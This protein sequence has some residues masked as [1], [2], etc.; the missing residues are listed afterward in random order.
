[1]PQP[2]RITSNNANVGEENTTEAQSATG[3][4]VKLAKITLLKAE[5]AVSLLTQEAAKRWHKKPMQPLILLCRRQKSLQ[6]K[7]RL[8]VG[9]SP[10]RLQNRQG[11]LMKQLKWLLI[12][13]VK[14]ESIGPIWK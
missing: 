4:A 13:P 8:K 2:F 11:E 6:I 10:C 14:R 9:S 3:K 5:K 1:M 12:K 7:R